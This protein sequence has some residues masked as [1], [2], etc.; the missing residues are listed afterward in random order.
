MNSGETPKQ[1]KPDQTNH[2]CETDITFGLSCND[3]VQATLVPHF[4]WL[5][6]VFGCTNC[7]GHD[8]II[9]LQRKQDEPYC[10]GLWICH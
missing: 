4:C 10:T 9:M 5:L 7:N 6:C 3:P 8:F 2:T 1:T